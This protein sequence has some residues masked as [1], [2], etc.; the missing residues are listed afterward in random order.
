MLGYK[1]LRLKHDKY[2]KSCIHGTVR[3]EILNFCAM[4]EQVRSYLLLTA[5]NSAKP[6]EMLKQMCKMYFLCFFPRLTVVVS[7]QQVSQEQEESREEEEESE[8]RQSPWGLSFGGGTP[9]H[10][11]PDTGLERSVGEAG[12]RDTTSCHC[13][14]SVEKSL[15]NSNIQWPT[16]DYVVILCSKILPQDSTDKLYWMWSTHEWWV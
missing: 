5:F 2:V 13:G 10:V 14:H 16:H 4:H 3:S 12:H 1:V 15:W 6:A 8:G 7:V 9:C 11:L